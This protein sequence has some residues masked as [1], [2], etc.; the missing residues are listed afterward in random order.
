MDLN[1]KLVLGNWKLNKNKKT[2]K[3]FFKEFNQFLKAEKF[4]VKCGIA[5]SPLLIPVVAKEIS[6]GVS[7]IAQNCYFH[8]EGAFT[9]EV[10][11]NQLKDYKVAY[12]LVG[13]SERRYLFGEKDYEI[14]KKIEFLILNDLT[15]ILC[16]GETLQQFENQQT[17]YI[18]HNQLKED[19]T[20]I[21]FNGKNIIFAYEPI[22]AIGT[23]K[24][25]SNE[26]IEKTVA[27]IRQVIKE[28][29]SDKTA[30]KAVI[31]YGGSVNPNNIVELNKIPNINGFLVGGASLKAESFFQL[32]KATNNS[33]TSKN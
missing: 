23:G 2:T 13:H 29:F 20:N 4:N 1:K 28:L 15:P 31:L 26:I 14:N 9:G 18:L 7:L 5:P 30:K 21:N 25:A 19:L 8:N 24:V 17:N 12:S 22:W 6:K 32:I 10:S 27:Y 33:V 3:D 11:I 16:I